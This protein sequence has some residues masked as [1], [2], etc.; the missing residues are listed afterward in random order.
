MHVTQSHVHHRLQFLPHQRHI[1]EQ[2]Q[3]VLDGEFQNIRNGVAVKLHRQRF[4]VIAPAIAHF[5]L[6][7]NVRHEVHFNAP[8]PIALAGFASPAGYVEAES[9][10]LVS[11]LARL[12]QHGEKV[13]DGREN[14]RICSWI[15]AR[16]APD[17]RLVDANHLVDLLGSGQRFVRARFLARSVNCPGQRTVKD[18]VDQGAFSAAAHACH[19]GHHAQR[20]ADVHVLQ[21]MLASA[22]DGEPF[23][24]ERPRPGA[25]QHG[26][27]A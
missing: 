17:R 14:L 6:H 7:V 20:N 3:R 15:G 9:S 21:V 13:A 8:L 5:A 16:R 23:A 19:H 2:R 26:R 25:L 24:R 12:R 4:L 10:R 22:G 1:D 27:I 18:V 11:T